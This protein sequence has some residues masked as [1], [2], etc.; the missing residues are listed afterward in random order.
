MINRMHLSGII[1][2]Q[3]PVI[4]V[5]DEYH[6]KRGWSHPVEKPKLFLE[7]IKPGNLRDVWPQV[8]EG[9]EQ[10][11]KTT[12][13]WITEDI[14]MALKMGTCNLH[15]GTVNGEYKGFLILQKQDNY[16]SVS[17]HVWAGYSEGK[18]FNL[19]EQSTEQLIE[20]AQSVEAKKITFSSTRKGWA[21][22][23]L[24][25]GFKPSPLVTYEMKL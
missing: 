21:K 3:D 6:N 15:I 10:V 25:V 13:A 24:K 9:L 7:W 8:K 5:A 4:S 12:D 22:Q 17:L 11:E 23:A 19:L 2:H 1:P 18:D 14:Y 20:W 16:G